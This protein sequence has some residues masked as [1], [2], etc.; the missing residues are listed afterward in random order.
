[1][2][3]LLVMACLITLLATNKANNSSSTTIP[4]KLVNGLILFEATI[5]Q[6]N[7][8]YI[9]D[10]GADHII[11]NEGSGKGE[12]TVFET[13]GGSLEAYE[14]ELN[15]LQITEDYIR[16]LDEAYAAPL[17]NLEDALGYKISGIIGSRVFTPHSL[18]INYNDEQLLIYEQGLPAEQ[19]KG[20]HILDFDF[21]YGVPLIKLKSQDQ[22]L[23]FIMDSGASKHFIDV[24]YLLSCPF[25]YN[26]LA[27][28]SNIATAKTTL[29]PSALVYLKHLSIG[30][31]P[32]RTP[33]MTADLKLLSD[34]LGDTI[35]GLISLRSLSKDRIILDL[36]SKKIYY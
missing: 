30:R 27:S 28:T 1:M 31:D 4:F 6:Y 7:G 21:S 25:G 13:I 11:I 23:N 5:D 15:F 14:T 8:Y 10:T 33:F 34:A 18:E 22:D 9:L 2:R 32:E 3:I 24:D 26:L 20:M 29:R 16:E 19:L 35:H 12:K 17:S 36:Q